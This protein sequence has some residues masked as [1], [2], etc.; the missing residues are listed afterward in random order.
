MSLKCIYEGLCP[1]YMACESATDAL[2]A[3]VDKNP[4]DQS[5]KQEQELIVQMRKY[6]LLSVAERIDCGR[7]QD[8]EECADNVSQYS[9]PLP[10]GLVENTA[11][12]PP[13][14]MRRSAIQIV[15]NNKPKGF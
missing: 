10:F 15:N 11:F 14:E 3:F 9:C 1:A 7:F 5:W 2:D 6:A 12:G 4:V 13:E 8:N